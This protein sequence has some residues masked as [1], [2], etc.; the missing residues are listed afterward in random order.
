VSTTTITLTRGRALST[1]LHLQATG[2]TR[3]SATSSP[4]SPD[5]Y[6]LADECGNHLQQQ[7]R[8]AEG[9]VAWFHAPDSAP[10]VGA[11]KQKHR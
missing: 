6:A 4:L 10:A 5:S 11:F 1:T 8:G 9:F 3:L 7:F 2:L